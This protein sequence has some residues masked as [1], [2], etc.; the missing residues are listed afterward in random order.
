MVSI[1]NWGVCKEES[2]SFQHKESEWLGHRKD[3][4]DPK[5]WTWITV[6]T[7]N[8]TGGWIMVGFAS[9]N[10]IFFA[11]VDFA[12]GKG[13]Q[14]GGNSTL[15]EELAESEAIFGCQSRGEL[16]HPGVRGQGLC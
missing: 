14:F 4:N 9:Q 8:K 7:R 12:L 16:C 11:R 15:K 5:K 10:Q 6:K 1:E 13:V 2:V 3:Q